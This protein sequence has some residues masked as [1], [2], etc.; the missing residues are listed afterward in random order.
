M[1]MFPEFLEAINL[2][3]GVMPTFTTLFVGLGMV[4]GGLLGLL[5]EA[6]GN[7]NYHNEFVEGFD[8]PEWVIQRLL[9]L[10]AEDTNSD[11]DNTDDEIELDEPIGF[12]D[13][14]LGFMEFFKVEPQRLAFA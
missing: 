10:D 8:V 3:L 11:T 5:E 7:Y 12:M 6:K 4:F 13:P 9:A 1:L 14:I 2:N